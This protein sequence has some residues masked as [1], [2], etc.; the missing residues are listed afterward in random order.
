MVETMRL[1]NWLI[2]FVLGGLVVLTAN[3]FA[4][5]AG[6]YSSEELGRVP[7]PGEQAVSVQLEQERRELDARERNLAQK[8]A[9]LRESEDH[10]RGEI[11][12]SETLRDEITALLD[13]INAAHGDEIGR[14]IKV[15]EKMRGSQA[16]PI[17]SAM[18]TDT[19]IPILRG[20]RADKAA[21]ILA[22]MS[23]KKAAA[24]S[25]RLNADPAAELSR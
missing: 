4:Q 24:L 3:S 5:D 16:A 20:M 19:V 22:A 14:Q 13:K 15:Y 25:E 7:L 8:E 9:L 23:P 18:E 17:L 12:K 10:I 2:P 1:N 11:T 21:K 6:L